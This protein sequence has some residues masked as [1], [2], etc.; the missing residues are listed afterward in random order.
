MQGL[1][2]VLVL[3][4][5]CWLFQKPCATPL[6]CGQALASGAKQLLGSHAARLTEGQQAQLGNHSIAKTMF[7][8]TA[9]VSPHAASAAEGISIH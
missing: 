5:L 3:V 2:Y 7:A 8:W 6:T 1:W 4:D 9:P